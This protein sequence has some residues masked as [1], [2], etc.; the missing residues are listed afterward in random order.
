[1]GAVAALPVELYLVDEPVGGA[2]LDEVGL[3]EAAEHG[4]LPPGPVGESTVAV[5]RLDVAAADADTYE[6]AEGVKPGGEQSAGL[7]G[8]PLRDPCQRAAATCPRVSPTNGL[9]PRIG[10]SSWS[11]DAKK[12]SCAWTPL[13]LRSGDGLVAPVAVLRP[14]SV[15]RLIVAT[16]FVVTYGVAMPTVT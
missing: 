8:S 16:A 1:M 12:W 13:L 2:L 10:G 14:V 4:V 7:D 15:I 11:K 6:V 9:A 3:H 5:G